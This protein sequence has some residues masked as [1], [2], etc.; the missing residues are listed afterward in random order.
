M[1][2]SKVVF[3]MIL[4]LKNTRANVTLDVLYVTNTMYSRQVPL[5]MVF[6]HKLSAADVTLVSG[7]RMLRSAALSMRGVVVNADR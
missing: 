6:M 1:Y 5:Q 4:A 3:K 2:I 7:V